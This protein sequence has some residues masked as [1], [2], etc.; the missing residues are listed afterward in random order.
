M[1]NNTI[2]KPHR[3]RLKRHCFGD[4]RTRFWLRH[5]GQLIRFIA[6]DYYSA[7]STESRHFI[8]RLTHKRFRPGQHL[9]YGRYTQE[10]ATWY[11]TLPVGVW[12]EIIPKKNNNSLPENAM[13]DKNVVM[14]V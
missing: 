3:G 8:K 5:N 12:C 13:A 1:D 2:T 6:F 14:E 7:G 9:Q 10:I 11:A 4:T